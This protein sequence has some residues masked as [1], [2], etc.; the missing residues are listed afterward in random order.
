M[1]QGIANMKIYIG[2][3]KFQI[4]FKHLTFMFSLF[5]V[6]ACGNCSVVM[7]TERLWQKKHS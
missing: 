3:Q 1:H 4:T 6:S 2:S 7:V 5:T